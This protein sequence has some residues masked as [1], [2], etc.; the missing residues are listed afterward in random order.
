[1]ERLQLGS[2]SSHLLCHTSGLDKGLYSREKAVEVSGVQ[3]LAHCYAR[4]DSE[5]ADAKVLCQYTCQYYKNLSCHM[6]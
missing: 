1:M 2:P 4:A 5:S 6:S 3:Y